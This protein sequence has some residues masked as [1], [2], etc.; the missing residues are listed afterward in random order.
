[1]TSGPQLLGAS[2]EVDVLAPRYVQRQG[3]KPMHNRLLAMALAAE[4]DCWLELTRGLV[5]YGAPL[6][7]VARHIKGA[8]TGLAAKALEY[9]IHYTISGAD[10]DVQPAVVNA[11]RRVGMNVDRPQSVLTPF[12]RGER[13]VSAVIERMRTT[14]AAG[15]VVLNRSGSHR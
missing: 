5:D 6:S 1:V 13:A 8:D 14:V 4:V 11:M 3:Q 15:A 12:H 7:E 2:G 9:T 10:P